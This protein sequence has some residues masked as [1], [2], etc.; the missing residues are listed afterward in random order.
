MSTI[1]EVL[2]IDLND[3]VS[4]AVREKIADLEKTIASQRATISKQSG[5]IKKLQA[6]IDDGNA[7][8]LVLGKVREKYL[9]LKTIYDK[10]SRNVDTCVPQQ[11]F[12]II[13]KIL[14][15]AYGQIPTGGGWHGYRSG[16]L[17]G[18]LLVNFHHCKDDLCAV[19]RVVVP[20]HA[21]LI[22]RVVSFRMPWDYPKKDVLN[23]LKELPYNTNGCMFGIHE[24]WVNEGVGVKNMPWDMIM[25]SPF[26]LEDDAFGLLINAIQGKPYM[27]SE[28][29]NLFAIPKFN[30]GITQEQKNRMA[31]VV[32][33]YNEQALKMA[34]VIAF[35]KNGLKTFPNEIVEKF[36]AKAKPEANYCLLSWQWFPIEWQ[37]KFLKE[38]PFHEAW[39][40]LTSHNCQ[41]MDEDKEAF[42]EEYFKG[43]AV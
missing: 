10:E 29:Y 11:Q 25:K 13:S 17:L 24:Y 16:S 27:K 32:L 12:N 42:M 6:H 40:I 1:E 31:E 5:E 8:A 4:K 39:K 21:E 3:V 41:W 35:V 33:G 34:E 22:P 19:L 20:S 9:A 43:S 15:M 38:R 18:N 30:T 2:D 14:E 23:F 7:D 28:A 37:K 36:F 26:I